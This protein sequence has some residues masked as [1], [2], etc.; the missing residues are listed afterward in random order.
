M[1]K[2]DEELTSSFFELLKL[3][4]KVSPGANDT[5]EK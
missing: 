4:A 5:L 1:F 3:C 2:L